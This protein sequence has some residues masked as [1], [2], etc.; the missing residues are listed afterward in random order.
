M[1]NIQAVQ[2]EERSLHHYL[3]CLHRVGISRFI[4]YTYEPSLAKYERNI[5]SLKSEPH[6]HYTFHLFHYLYPS[7]LSN[8]LTNFELFSQFFNVK[9]LPTFQHAFQ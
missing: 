5:R 9:S 3:N 6:L 4:K 7:S 1:S 8:A 2:I